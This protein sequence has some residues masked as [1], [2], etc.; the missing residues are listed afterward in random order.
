MILPSVKET[1]PIPQLDGDNKHVNSESEIELDP[2]PRTKP[3]PNPGNSDESD[4]E[5]EPSQV[6]TTEKGGNYCACFT[7][8]DSSRKCCW[9]ALH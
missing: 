8:L 7:T 6:R 5:P 1:S 3:N 9:Q 2:E 4:T